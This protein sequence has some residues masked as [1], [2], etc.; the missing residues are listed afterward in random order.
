[1]EMPL[2]RMKRQFPDEIKKASA[3]KQVIVTSK[4]K[5]T[6][7]HEAFFTIF[8]WLVVCLDMGLLIYAWKYSRLSIGAV[9]ALITLI[10]N[11]YTPIA[12]FNVI[13]VQYKL[14]K[15]AWRRFADLLDLKEDSQ[16]QEGIPFGTFS[17]EVSVEDLSFSYGD[18][19]VLDKISITIKKGEKV[20]FVG[21]SGSGKSTLAKILVGL[22]KYEKGEVLFDGK[23]L[24]GFSLES[25]YE[26]VSYF[27]QNTPVFDG[28]IR[29]NLVFDKEI[30]EEDIKNSLKNVQLFPLLAS[31]DNG[32]E[33][34]IGERGACLSGGEKQRLALARLWFEQADMVIL[35]EAT[36]ALDNLTESIVMENV[37]EKMDGATV[38]AIVHR[39]AS[40][41]GFDRIVVFK[42]GRIAGNGT[43]EKLLAANP[44]FYELY[45][46]EKGAPQL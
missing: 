14:N 20:A 15:A 36:S 26:R 40:V 35:D 7:I 5:M 42:E 37:V 46:K 38:I 32:L 4:V 41:R 2:F 34:K 43:F 23:P 1:M 25:L 29:E 45:R 9:V 10:D 24:K 30:P 19:K 27:P 44:Y 16:L 3:A 12:I 39:L 17:N 18:K 21:E 6:M 31:L 28:T 22:L 13:Y 11:A 8:A 33:T